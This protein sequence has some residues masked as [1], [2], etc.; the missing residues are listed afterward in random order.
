MIWSVDN[1]IPPNLPGNLPS[2]ITNTTTTNTGK[3]NFTQQCILSKLLSV[4]PR[5][6]PGIFYPS[7]LHFK[8]QGFWMIKTQHDPQL[9]VDAKTREM[10]GESSSS[11]WQHDATMQMSFSKEKFQKQLNRSTCKSSFS[12][13]A[14]RIFLSLSLDLGQ[15]TSGTSLRS[16][17]RLH[18]PGFKR[19]GWPSISGWCEWCVGG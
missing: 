2:K 14:S 13:E 12:T 9:A 1:G 18:P 4:L 17:Y 3:T 8:L 19:I 15:G 10:A 16:L 6:C 11:T 7:K 5:H